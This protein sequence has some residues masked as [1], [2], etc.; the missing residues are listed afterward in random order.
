MVAVRNMGWLVL[1]AAL[2]VLAND[3]RL[4]Y[5]SGLFEP[6]KLSQV[7]IDINRA[8]L[9]RIGASL[10]PWASEMLRDSLSV[11]AAP[12]IGVAGLALVWVGSRR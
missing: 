1:L 8:S 4:W 5:A 2:F 6:M 9:T 3:V 11:W 12:A 10:A 7:W